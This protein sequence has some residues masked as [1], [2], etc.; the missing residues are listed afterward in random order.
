MYCLRSVIFKLEDIWSQILLNSSI[1]IPPSL[2]ITEKERKGPPKKIAKLQTNLIYLSFSK[3][4]I[5]KSGL[6]SVSFPGKRL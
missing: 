4:F 1:P 5:G 3:Y 6:H 2:W